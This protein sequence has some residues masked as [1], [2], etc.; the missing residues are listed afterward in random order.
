MRPVCVTISNSI[1]QNAIEGRSRLRRSFAIAFDEIA[2]SR[3]LG[4]ALSAVQDDVQRRAKTGAEKHPVL[5]ALVTAGVVAIL[6][7]GSGQGASPLK[8]K[9]Q[10]AHSTRAKRHT[11]EKRKK[12]EE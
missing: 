11:V 8:R 9:I 3:L 1:R 2:P 10:H 7:E 6:K 5:A 4:R 12:Q